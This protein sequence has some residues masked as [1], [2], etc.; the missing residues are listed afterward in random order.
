MI[1]G[2]GVAVDKAAEM[3]MHPG[4]VIVWATYVDAVTLGS[5]TAAAKA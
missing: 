2:R 3:G 5:R 1:L 4:L